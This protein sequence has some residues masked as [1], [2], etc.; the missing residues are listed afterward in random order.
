MPKKKG[1]KKESMFDKLYSIDVSG[2]T[3]KKGKYDYLPWQKAIHHL[4]EIYPDFK[5][6]VVEHYRE[7]K[8]EEGLVRLAYPYFY[9]PLVKG[10]A[11]QTEVEIE[12]KVQSEILA[13]QDYRMNV[14]EKPD[15]SDINTAIRRCLVKNLALFGLGLSVY[16]GGENWKQDVEQDDDPEEPKKESKHSSAKKPWKVDDDAPKMPTEKKK[17]PE[18]NTEEFLGYVTKMFDGKV[19]PLLTESQL[20]LAEKALSK[21]PSDKQ[22]LFKNKYPRMETFESVAKA[23]Q[24]MAQI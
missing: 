4:L 2:H 20:K 5:W 23:K 24:A 6:R 21:L 22:N 15:W 7:I 1:E 18:E 3:E 19:V 11:V 16:E 9:D 10:L 13:V 8:K 17:T 14:I 12:D